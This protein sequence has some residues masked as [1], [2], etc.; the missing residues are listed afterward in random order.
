MLIIPFLSMH[1]ITIYEIGLNFS[2]LIRKKIN[3]EI[4]QN[5]KEQC[6]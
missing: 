1:Y 2:I 4:F 3:K 5:Y 6:I